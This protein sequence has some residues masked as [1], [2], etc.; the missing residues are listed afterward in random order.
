VAGEVFPRPSFALIVRV[1]GY[2]RAILVCAAVVA[3]AGC[4][5]DAT[6]GTA[7][8]TEEDEVRRVV[9][10]ATKALASGDAV[11]VC[12]LTT[13][14]G[15]RELIGSAS[16]SGAKTCPDVMRLAHDAMSKADLAGY[17]HIKITW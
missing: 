16:G 5:G 13:E 6:E 17:D 1:M 4:G 7:T 9:R 3:A 8:A 11:R 15:K 12:E 14:A 10:E 2:V